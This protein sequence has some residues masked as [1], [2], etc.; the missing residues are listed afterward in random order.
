M[1]A[2]RDK[3]ESTAMGASIHGA[4]KGGVP[5]IDN[6]FKVFHYNRSG[7]QVVFNDFI[8]VF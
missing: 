1:A 6:L 8:I 3:L 5:A 2:E 7:L 4:T